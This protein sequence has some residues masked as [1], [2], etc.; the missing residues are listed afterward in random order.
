M[1][2]RTRVI[3]CNYIKGGAGKT[4]LAVHITGIL[5]ERTVGQILLM[6]C[7]SRP[8]SWKFFIGSRPAKNQTRLT[9][10]NGLDLWWNPPKLK[11]SRFKPIV[12]KDYETYDYVVIDTDSPPEEALT[13]L[14]DTRPDL[15]LIP[16]AESQ[17]HAIE[18]ISPF[19]N[20]LER[21]VKFERDSGTD[22]SPIVKVA[23]LG[24]ARDER[25]E[26]KSQLKIHN[27]SDV[28]IKLWTPM[29]NYAQDIRKA[30]KEKKFI[31]KYPNLEDT[32][33][34]FINLIVDAIPEVQ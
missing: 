4:T 27:F 9:P 17:S 32:K 2:R 13:L 30:L 23:P 33:D 20:D 14:S 8:D 7:D 29:N 25:D 1:N 34:Y 10:V 6:D 5:L 3:L 18:D 15:F 28:E 22:Y 21:E 16:I 19:L 24:L 26:I 11:G 31:W 12:K